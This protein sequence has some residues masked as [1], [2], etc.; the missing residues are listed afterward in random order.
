MLS[1]LVRR[2]GHALVIQAV[3]ALKR[4]HPRLLLVIG[5]Q[6]GYRHAIERMI[7]DAGIRE[8]AEL[9]GLVPEADKPALYR[10]CDVFC[11]PSDETEESFE[12]EGFG[13][14][15]LEAAAAGRIAV[16]S[17]AGGIADAVE[18]GASGFLVE[19]GNI[20]QLVQVLD[21]ILSGPEQF[22]RMRAYARERAAGFDWSKQMETILREL[23]RR[24]PA[25]G[26]THG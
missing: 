11:M 25:A 4:K 10:A 7:A 18:D 16:G 5:G 23:A 13:I 20:E 2:K 15:L 9:I 17:R 19:P 21:R 8:H 24:V 22:D 12:T 6:G 3:A 26:T 14:A 1:R